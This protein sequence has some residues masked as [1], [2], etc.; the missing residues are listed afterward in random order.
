MCWV[1]KQTLSETLLKSTDNANTTI[2]ITKPNITIKVIDE[3]GMSVTENIIVE[4]SSVYNCFWT[5][6]LI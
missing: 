3:N 5:F 1:V 4:V 2:K 6:N